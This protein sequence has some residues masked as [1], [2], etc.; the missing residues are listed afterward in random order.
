MILFI[1][2]TF[3]VLN[4]F[5]E[6]G[7]AINNNSVML[8]EAVFE[9]KYIIA[10]GFY[11][12]IYFSMN[13]VMMFWDYLEDKYDDV[14]RYTKKQEEK[15]YNDV[16]MTEQAAEEFK[17]NNYKILVSTNLKRKFSHAE[18]GY[19]LEE[20]NRIMNKFLMDK[21]GVNPEM[22]EGGFLY[23]FGNF[24]N[25]IGRASCRERV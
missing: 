3:S 5:N 15:A 1:Y 21:T 12:I 4:L 14:H 18:L 11:I 20:Q 8:F 10:V 7:A 23:S 22:F 17:I 6:W 19:N 25:E 9:Y 24:N 2:N 16:M 13:L